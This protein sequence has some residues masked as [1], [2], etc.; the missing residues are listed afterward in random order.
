MYEYDVETMGTEGLLAYWKFNEGE[1]STVFDHSG[2][3]RDITANGTVTW[4]DVA[5]P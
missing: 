2:N 1:G 4:E 5:L 3:N